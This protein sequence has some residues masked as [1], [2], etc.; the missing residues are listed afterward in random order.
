MLLIVVLRRLLCNLQYQYRW[1]RGFD[2]MHRGTYHRDRLIM[3]REVRIRDRLSIRR[4]QTNYRFFVCLDVIRKSAAAHL[5]PFKLSVGAT[6][7]QVLP[8]FAEPCIKKNLVVPTPEQF[9][10]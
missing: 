3:C 9:L 5:E 1:I 8:G 6:K 4:Q 10:M 7:R 2:W